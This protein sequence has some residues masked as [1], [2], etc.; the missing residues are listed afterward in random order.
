MA[1]RSGLARPHTGRSRGFALVIV[2]ICS[3]AMVAIAIALVFTA[4]ANRLVSVKG[5]AID[6]SETIAIAGLERAVA[7]AERVAAV[8]RDYDLLLD[9]QEN[10]D[11]NTAVDLQTSPQKSTSGLPRFTDGTPKEYETRNY[12]LVPFNAGAYL[13]RF[14][15]DADDADANRFLSV[16]TG[17]RPNGGKCEEG[18]AFTRGNNPF[19]DRN[20]GVWISVVGIYPGTN[21]D[22]ARH[23][24]ALRR[25][26]ISTVALPGPAIHVNGN[27]DIRGD[28][29]FC[30]DIG[31]IAAGGNLDFGGGNRVCGQPT[32]E[33]NTT[34]NPASAA[35]TCRIGPATPEN[36]DA[37]TP[38][39]DPLGGQPFDEPFDQPPLTPA[40]FAVDEAFWF[41][42]E[43][44]KCNFYVVRDA[45]LGGLFFWDSALDGPAGVCAKLPRGELPAADDNIPTPTVSEILTAPSS[46]TK[47]CW[48]PIAVT[49]AGAPVDLLSFGEMN[50]NEWRPKSAEVS[51][52]STAATIGGV[53]ITT[54]YALTRKPDW[55]T[56]K[57]AWKGV[58]GKPVGCGS[59][60]DAGPFAGSQICNGTAAAR[61]AVVGSDVKF[62]SSA[63]L[64][65][66]TYRFS[67]GDVVASAVFASTPRPENDLT[68][69][70]WGLGT[71]IVAGRFTGDSP[72][73]LGFGQEHAPFAS[74]VASN[75]VAFSGGSRP[76]LAGSLVA[77]SGN[78]D[79][80]NGA[81]DNDF[82]FHGMIV[83]GNGNLTMESGSKLHMHYDDDLF[84]A[85]FVV[86]AATTTS[87]TIR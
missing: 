74:I 72:F 11:C 12:Q 68:P 2:V 36:P 1:R 62:E 67:P 52:L 22:T 85:S 28:L 81:G 53:V 75:G 73:A 6:Q 50:G 21:P 18:P 27:I 26:H 80:A 46:S 65:A 19:R 5:S 31:E 38:R 40:N 51:A 61:A 78:I 34:G 3:V 71:F 29:H 37:C 66:G 87:R 35:G 77:V 30:S 83:A 69:Q 8:E 58:S 70:G 55:S 64:P 39:R 47:R 25:F 63:A 59:G 79:F 14:D 57:T 60:A 45:A 15:D 42:R 7:Y 86:P 41:N 54:D 32:A 10:I 9:P 48:V 56:C 16:F 44:P 84:G 17:N 4:G 24:T 23:R 43:Q 33:G 13:V 49:V 76:A 82:S 20:R